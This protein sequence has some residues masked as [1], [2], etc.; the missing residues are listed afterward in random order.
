MAVFHP[1][2]RDGKDDNVSA[3]AR[4]QTY[5]QAAAPRQDKYRLS[6]LTYTG[7]QFA[8]AAAIQQQ[9]VAF[10]GLIYQPRIL[11]SSA[12]IEMA[13]ELRMPPNSVLRPQLRAFRDISQLVVIIYGTLGVLPTSSLGR[14]LCLDQ[15]S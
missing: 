3:A 7:S 2:T 1:I 12:P 13:L 15:G 4:P 11:S 8:P 10:V 5:R 14:S 9:F 6:E